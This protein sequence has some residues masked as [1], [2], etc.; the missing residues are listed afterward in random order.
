M[1]EIAQ[2]KI[3]SITHQLAQGLDPRRVGLTD[4]IEL[5]HW[6]QI[7]PDPEKIKDY[8]EFLR[9]EEKINNK[10]RNKLLLLTEV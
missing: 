9:F 3:L 2:N 4:L 8:A 10:N 7:Q 6:R 5:Q 1:N